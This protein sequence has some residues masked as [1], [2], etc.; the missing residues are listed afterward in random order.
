MR[1]CISLVSG[2][3]AAGG[4]GVTQ[5]SKDYL[6]KIHGM[7]NLIK[8]ETYNIDIL[9]LSFRLTFNSLV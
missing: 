5:K 7:C 2:E 8:L 6:H 1:S 3:I 9:I 4:P